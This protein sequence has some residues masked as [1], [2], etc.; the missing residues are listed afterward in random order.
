LG[1]NS[2]KKLYISQRS[3]KRRCNAQGIYFKS[4]YKNSQRKKFQVN[5]ISL[6]T[7]VKIFPSKTRF[8]KHNKKTEKIKLFN[9]SLIITLMK[10]ARGNSITKEELVVTKNCAR[11]NPYRK[12]VNNNSAVIYLRLRHEGCDKK[13]AITF[14]S[15]N[16]CRTDTTKALDGPTDYRKLKVRKDSVVIATNVPVFFL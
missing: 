8:I 16:Y 10:S 3:P 11:F 1:K 5:N 12:N 2:E 15:K 7:Q 6:K 9:R 14:S 4:S 13:K